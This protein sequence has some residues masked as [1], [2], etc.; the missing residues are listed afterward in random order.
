MQAT[1]LP[2]VVEVL[3]EMESTISASSTQDNETEMSRART[4]MSQ[5]ELADDNSYAQ[6]IIVFIRYTQ[7]AVR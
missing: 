5:I 6:C 1:R 3:E 4:C 2:L 7:A